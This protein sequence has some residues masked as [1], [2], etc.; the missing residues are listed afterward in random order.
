LRLSSNIPVLCILL[1]VLTAV[2]ALKPVGYIGGGGD[3]WQYLASARC[4][5]THGICIP[6][7]HW[8]ARWPLIAPMA[9]SIRLFGE[10]RA[11]VEL[12]PFLYTAAA[13][14]LFACLTIRLFG[15]VEALIAGAA[16]IATPVF[17]LG[18]LKPEVDV[19]ELAFLVAA[20]T[21]WHAAITRRQRRWAIATG[22]AFALAVQTRETSLAYLLVAGIVFLCSCADD[23]K[24]MLWAIPGFA[25]PVIAES[26]FLWH[27]AGDPLLRLHLALHHTQLQSSELSAGVDTSRSPLLNPAFIAGWHPSNGIHVCWPIDPILNLLSHPEI[28]MT[29]LSALL[30][31][32]SA[33]SGTRRQ[34]AGRFVLIATAG[35]TLLIYVLAI[36]P[37]PRMFLP[38]VTT[39]SMAIGAMVPISWYIGR[40]TIAVAVL[41]ILFAQSVCFIAASFST[42]RLEPV[43]ASWIARDP[44]AITMDETTKRV[45][46]LVPAIQNLPVNDDSRP[47]H[48]T[49]SGL[50]CYGPAGQRSTVVRSYKPSNWIIFLFPS[51][52]PS[53][54]LFAHS[55]R[56]A[57]SDARPIE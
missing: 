2:T 25:A 20:V 6:H 8:S 23:R 52:H 29:L 45:L 46:A 57:G 27:L 11:T 3:E 51:P 17:S 16:L 18:T 10:T 12:V 53:L 44:D 4:W 19:V 7:D 39:S 42:Y 48:L 9:A 55:P 35:A 32:A 24:L 47:L 26:L 1:L 37:K 14:L 43:A 33:P 31:L 49:V 15:R 40:R 30:L 21:A 50:G 22:I 56:N 41:A 36:D 5:A 28:G 34:T 54:C 13:L 38:L